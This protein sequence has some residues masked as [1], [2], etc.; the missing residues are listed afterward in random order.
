MKLSTISIGALLCSVLAGQFF[1]QTAPRKYKAGQ[2]VEYV[3]NG[4]WFK[5]VIV[6]V[7][8]DADVANFGPYHVYRVHSLGFNEYEDAWV[9]DFS[10]ARAQLRPAGSGPTEPVPAGEASSEA[11]K[12]ARAAT[13]ASSNTPPAKAYHCVMYIVDHLEDTASFTLTANGA[14][15]DSE[16][17]RGTYGFNSSSSTLTFHGGNYDGQRAEF[18]T[19]GGRARL[20]ILG[21]SGRRV[22]DC[23]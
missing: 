17:K 2:Q 14:Y 16:G 10:D 9:S 19:S 8:S 4:K 3:N 21:P 11:P 5:A 7:A 20:H 18:E 23:D 15:T 6:K 1:A 13:A 12:P 22:I